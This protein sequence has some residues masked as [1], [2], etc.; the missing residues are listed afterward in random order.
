[1]NGPTEERALADSCCSIAAIHRRSDR[2]SGGPTG[3]VHRQSG[4]HH[5][6]D[7]APTSRRST[8]LVQRQSGEHSGRP[9]AGQGCGAFPGPHDHAQANPSSSSGGLGPHRFHRQSC[10]HCRDT[11]STVPTFSS[12]SRGRRVVDL[13]PGPVHRLSGGH[14]TSKEAWKS[15]LVRGSA[16]VLHENSQNSRFHGSPN[17]GRS[18]ATHACARVLTACTVWSFHPSC[19]LCAS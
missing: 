19:T 3:A 17:S 13:L 14:S 8:H 2:L 12:T 4:G 11:P 1:M 7:D 9:C 5:R 18:G 10:G 6:R 15:D 16:G